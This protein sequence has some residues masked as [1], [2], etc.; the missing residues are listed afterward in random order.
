M[1]EQ[2]VRVAIG[3]RPQELTY[4]WTGDGELQVGDPVEVPPPWWAEDVSEKRDRFSKGVVTGIGSSYTG[5]TRPITRR[6]T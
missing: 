4:R 2:V 1:S 6:L 3:G 5:P